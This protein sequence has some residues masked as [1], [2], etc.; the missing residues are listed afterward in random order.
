VNA[1]TA[2]QY[3][4]AYGRSWF[5]IF[6]KPY[7]KA[8]ATL[9]GILVGEPAKPLDD[10]VAVL[11]CLIRGQ[12]AREFLEGPVARQVGGDAFGSLWN[13]PTSDWSALWAIKK[14]EGEC[15]E[16]K[17]DDRFRQIYADLDAQP[18]VKPL[19]Q[20]IGSDLKPLVT[21]LR[22][23][24][25]MVRLDLRAAFNAADV[26]VIPFATLSARFRQWL[27]APEAISRW[28]AY[29]VRRRQVDSE[30]MAELAAEI[31]AG[32]IPDSEA[33][34]SCE[35]AY[36]EA[37]IRV[38]FHDHPELSA[39]EG[40]THGRLIQ[41][42]QELDRSR[43][44][45]ARHEVAYSHFERL[46]RASSEVGELGL[47]RR[48]IQK[49]RR[50]LPIRKLITEA[51]RAVQ[52]IK[53][54]FM[55]S[56]ISVAQYLEP[57]GIEFDLL[58][59]D[60]ASQVQP[61]DALGAVAR[62]KQIIVVGDRKQL[63][64]TRFFNR[65]LGEEG[66]E[67]AEPE[68]F[69]AGDMESILGLCCAQGMHERMLR[70]HYRSRHHSLIAVSNHE[71]YEDRLYVVP[72]PGK[73]VSGRGLAFHFVES[74][75][76]DRGGSATNR[77]EAKVVAQ[78]VM[79]H[80]RECPDKSLGV[81]TFSVTQ[82]DAILDELELLRRDDPSLEAFFI[83]A[84]AE[85]F[86]VKNLENIQGDER[87]VV[88]ISV[89]YAKDASGFMAM[90]FGPLSNDGGER[91]LNVLITRARDCCCVFS[92]IRGD[93]IDLSRARARGSQ[94]LRTFLKY[95]ETGLMDTG[96][97]TE[98]DHDSEFERQV[99]RALAA[100]GCQTCPQVGVAGFFIDLAVVD[101]SH[102]GRYLLGIECD[103]AN[104]HRSRSARDRDR[105]R[106]AVLEDRG[107]ILHRIWSTDWFH[108]PEEELRKTFA[109]IEAA[110]AVWASRHVGIE[111]ANESPAIESTEIERS[112]CA[113]NGCAANPGYSSQPYVIASF[114]I[115]ATQDIPDVP[116]Y[117]LAKVVARIIQDEGPIHADEIAR[118]VTQLWGLQRTGKRI[119]EAV[120]QA[121]KV[122]SRHSG[123]KRDGE[124]YWLDG[125]QEVT[126]RDRSV[127]ESNT[128]RQPKMLPPTE[129]R[130][131]LTA[132]VEVH[133][134][135]ARDE[136]II[137]AARL[138][139]F[140]ATSTQLREVI[141]AEVNWLVQH[142]GLD[143]RNGKLY[144]KETTRP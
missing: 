136:V 56:P 97:P 79:A 57:G 39:F 92:S 67:D 132:I 14:W 114:R 101:P 64:P 99:S 127:V 74:G 90:N 1:T 94:A 61:V 70:W 125:Q 37:L 22:E 40:A 81:G 131:A 88:F 50:H 86:F 133:L 54:V 130:R 116:T 82:R 123:A 46:P 35:M 102:P 5:R 41:K 43:I 18:D 138:F 108:R 26:L 110:K 23:L 30:G 140:K 143:E 45:L 107:W 62:A 124:F 71:F 118:R 24:V 42:F 128:L 83:T 104:Y 11:D 111:R 76:F 142:Q 21:E 48:E 106:S 6:R 103:G 27:Q 105:L 2:R 9:R 85:P 80:A 87:D 122:V 63:P 28:V 89:G 135:A 84:T 20:Q 95:A 117:K 112:Q 137:E 15:V 59:I 44:D 98:R 38:S 141:D 134:G 36:F 13:G 53:P 100:H 25:A 72:S 3:L 96:S 119:R 7:R 52:A 31:H 77:I 139:G 126:I 91:R 121:L 4:A 69:Q 109:A 16:A 115:E 55:M 93:D 29:N 34:A 65:M 78:A 60:E 58:L 66:Q 19:L 68:Q 12:K 8:Q 33:V 47:V 113:G 51:G 73:P 17:I 32:R 10:R 49:K 144:A 75:V 120:D 129:I